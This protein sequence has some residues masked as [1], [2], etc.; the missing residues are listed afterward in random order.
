MIYCFTERVIG[1]PKSMWV[2][3][4]CLLV[5]VALLPLASAC[6]ALTASTTKAGALVINEVVSS[7]KY[8][9]VDG[10][11]GSPDWIELYNASDKP[12]LLNGYGLSDNLRNLNKFVFSDLAI[13]PGEYLVVYA[14]DNNGVTKTDVPCTGF[15]LSKSGDFLYLV[16][17]YYGVVDQLEIPALHTDVSYARRSNGAFGYCASPTPGAANTSQ[18]EDSL[19]SLFAD[20]KQ[21]TLALSEVMPTGDADGHPWVELHNTGDSALQLENYYLSDSEANVTRF[22]M[23]VATIPPDGY[24]C[25]WLSGL[26]SDGESGIHSTFKLSK[27]DTCVILADLR[28][29]V[30]D[31]IRWEA[32]VTAGVTVVKTE[33]GSAYTAFPTYAEKNATETFTE[34]GLRAMEPSDPVHISE[35]LK[36][37][38]LSAI[39]GDG[40]RSEWVELVNTSASAA[41]MHG[42]FLSDDETDLY[43]WALPE[44]TL[45]AG[46]YLLVFLS[47][48]NRTQGELHA[49][50]GLSDDENM[51]YLT[52]IDGMK[53]ES[54]ALNSLTRDNISIGRDGGGNLRYFAQPTPGYENAQGFE[55]AD[56]IGFFNPEGVFIS[57]VCA[58]N[59]I[60]SRKNDWV[61]LH[62]GG[63]E[64]V[65]LSGWYFSDSLR[66][67]K[68]WQIESLTIEPGGYAVIEATSHATRQKSGVAP[69]GIRTGGENLVLSDAQGK[70]VDVFPTGALKE[71]VSSGRIEADASTQRVFFLRQTRGKANS[72]RIARGYAPEPAFS[73]MGLYHSEAFN[74]TITCRDPNATVYYTTDG[75]KPTTES[76]RY[77]GPIAIDEN[78]VLRA[79]S[80]IDGKLMSGITTATYLFE[81]PHSVPVVCV[82][83]DPERV[84]E[85]LSVTD[86]LNKIENEAII[87]YYEADGTLGTTFPAGI[88]VKGAGTVIYAQK[89]ISLNL[90]A[91]YG[92][93]AVTYPFFPGYDFSTF[94]A[95]VVR[96][97]GQDWQ[98]ARMRDSYCQ[99]LVEGMYVD[100]SATRPV[101]V[102]V[103]GRYNGLYD[104]GED[105]N[106]EYLTTHYGVDSDA[107]DIIRRNSVALAGN[108]DDFL[109]LREYALNT[110]LSDDERFSEFAERID[111]AFFTDYFIAQTYVCNS[112]MFNQK[113]WRSQDNTVRW[114]PI[115]YDLDFGFRNSAPRDMIGQYFN[116]NGVASANGSL[117]YFEIYIGLKKNAAWRQYCV[118]RYVE[119]VVKYFNSARATAILDEMAEVLRAEMP[120][121]IEQWGKPKSM[122]EWE[123]SVASLRKTVE[124][125]PEYALE[126]MR[127]FFGVSRSEIDA[128]VEKYQ[129]EYQAELAATRT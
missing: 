95:L 14:A 36:H 121:Q 32:G 27:N 19:D 91:G 76:Q 107:V 81:T 2:R 68:K 90:R 37:N 42:Y 15:G 99:R 117:T 23:P 52:T 69:F 55:T 57:E 120:R 88:K 29:T 11:L 116:E 66:E 18:I 20:Q 62:N 71:G 127:H 77:E 61:E 47:G 12:I 48:K 58:V 92:Q 8:S 119:C 78:T 3:C 56:S 31:E 7:N 59:E 6:G 35:V 84:K 39:D 51:L 109:N 93:S 105:Q 60:K 17:A 114:R 5:A 125:R 96:N 106:K 115:F 118:E 124:N 70:Q 73:V 10:D 89:S 108:H 28:G 97:G 86:Q 41:S 128:L 123:S 44:V 4:V 46:G 22:Q 80:A 9:L 103:N 104:L 33:T 83:G 26:G 45:E 74:V 98:Y 82:N 65:D 79:A 34:L 75:G 85:S 112:D 101:V 25:V 54:I 13:G 64:T 50:F 30:L 113:Y 110:R 16:D 38:T 24:V 67:P 87:S 100:N 126:N 63:M 102:Y 49:S 21:E 111:V 94:S 43:K 122:R 40:D 129:A 1:M 72:D 53:T